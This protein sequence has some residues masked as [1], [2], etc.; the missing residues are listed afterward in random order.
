MVELQSKSHRLHAHLIYQTYKTK[1]EVS[2]HLVRQQQTLD[3][4]LTATL[5][6]HASMFSSTPFQTIKITYSG[7]GKIKPNPPH[8]LT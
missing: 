4:N 2:L 3:Q 5:P 1:D 8:C 7:T 6:I